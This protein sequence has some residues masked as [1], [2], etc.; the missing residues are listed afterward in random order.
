M[1]HEITHSVAKHGNERM[2]QAMVQQL[3]G[4]ALET[5]LSQKPKE[6]QELF[7]LSYGIGSEV[8]LCYH[9]RGSRKRK[10]ISTV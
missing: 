9:G 6:T 4:M 3:G 1:G 2:S 10:L 7:M 5:A 8:A